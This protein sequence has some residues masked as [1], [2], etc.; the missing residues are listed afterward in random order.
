MQ[1]IVSKLPGPLVQV[2]RLQS[3]AD[4]SLRIVKDGIGEDKI[5]MHLANST[6]MPDIFE[7]LLEICKL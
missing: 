5:F 3:L 2:Q 7:R 1:T 6:S 4:L